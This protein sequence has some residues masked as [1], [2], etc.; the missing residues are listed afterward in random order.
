MAI[1]THYDQGIAKMIA[2]MTGWWLDSVYDTD[3]YKWI[4]RMKHGHWPMIPVVKMTPER[5]AEQRAAKDFRQKF[6]G[7][8]FRTLNPAHTY[9]MREQTRAHLNLMEMN[10]KSKIF[11]KENIWGTS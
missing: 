6:P 5:L 10:R 4:Y 2:G 3:E 9:F 7:E 8:V 1:Y 11:G